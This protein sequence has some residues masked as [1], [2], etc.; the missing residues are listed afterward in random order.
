MEAAY[1]ST[2]A[3]KATGS[4]PSKRSRNPLGIAPQ[5]E[6]PSDAEQHEDAYKVGEVG[7]GLGQRLGAPVG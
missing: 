5:E 4:H 6:E 3:A 7:T 2:A 1:T